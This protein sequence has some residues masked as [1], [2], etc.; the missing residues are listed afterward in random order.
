M[1]TLTTTQYGNHGSHSNKQESLLT[2]IINALFAVELREELDAK[3]GGDK[4]DGAFIW[5]L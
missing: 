3:T 1:A 2:A 5:G 4:S